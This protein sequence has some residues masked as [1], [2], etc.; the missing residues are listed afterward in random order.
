MCFIVET[1]ISTKMQPISWMMPWPYVR[2]LWAKTIL[3]CVYVILFIFFI[4]PSMFFYP[5]HFTIKPN[6]EGLRAAFPLD[7]SGRVLTAS[8]Q[9]PAPCWGQHEQ[10]QV[11]SLVSPPN[12]AR[13]VVLDPESNCMYLCKFSSTDFTCPSLKSAQICTQASIGWLCGS[14]WDLFK[15]SS[16]CWYWLYNSSPA[17]LL[18]EI[19][20]L[21]NCSLAFDELTVPD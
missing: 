19:C 14:Q 7:G 4:F 5:T 18:C 6:R 11:H 17:V 13:S 10:C 1:R 8:S 16:S 21:V 2:K 20:V 9:W 12:G 3:R 15:K